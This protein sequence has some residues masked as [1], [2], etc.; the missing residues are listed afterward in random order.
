MVYFAVSW[1]FSRGRV[2]EDMVTSCDIFLA[3]VPCKALCAFTEEFLLWGV[4]VFYACASIHAGLRSTTAIGTLSW[5]H[6]MRFL[7]G[8]EIIKL[9]WLPCRVLSYRF[10]RWNCLPPLSSTAYPFVE[11]L[12]QIVVHVSWLICKV[13]CSGGLVFVQ[14]LT[15]RIFHLTRFTTTIMNARRVAFSWIISG[16]VLVGIAFEIFSSKD[17]FRLWIIRTGIAGTQRSGIYILL[18]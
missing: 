12:L 16:N 5:L 4:A 10:V 8:K 13:P 7:T 9:I 1:R 15:F 11:F 14:Q 2:L 3:D 6:H 18:A 17:V